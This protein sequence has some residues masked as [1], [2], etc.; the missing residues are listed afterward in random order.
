MALPRPHGKAEWIQLAELR[1][2]NILRTRIAANI[3]QLEVKICESGPPDR[4]PEPH[5]LKTALENL[6]RGGHLRQ[7]KPKGVTKHEEAIFYTL[8]QHYPE[9]AKSRIQELL[10]PYRVHR[11]L[12]DNA[13]YCS[14]VL[15][16]LVQD[17]FAA[18]P[19]YDY[20][21]KLPKPAPLDAVYRLEPHTIGVEVKNVREWVYPMSG[22]IWVMLRK[23]LEIDAVPF[24]IARKMP[25]ITRSVFSRLGVLGFEVYRQ[26]F[27]PLVANLLQDV[28]H[29][30]LLGY[31]DVIAAPSGP[32][33]PLV[34]YLQNT[35]PAQID[36][37]R[38]R[39]QAQRTLLTKFAINRNLGDPDM[40]DQQREAHYQ[41]FALAIFYEDEGEDDPEPF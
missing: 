25:Y 36:P 8:K 32:H 4:R 14:R 13:D 29:S 38:K 22:R 26:V 19:H 18:F 16:N 12:T 20:L 10:V 33:P 2:R 27:S 21:G 40:T 15:E 41:D 17:S 9:P 7:I 5:N 39:F 28:Q 1:I 23:C 24:F 3:R 31:K 11:M 30:D 35:L 37:Y 34:A 6:R